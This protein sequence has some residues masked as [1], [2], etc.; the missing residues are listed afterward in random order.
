ML[1]CIRIGQAVFGAFAQMLPEK[2]PAC[3]GGCDYICS[4]A[5]YDKSRTPWNYSTA[6][7]YR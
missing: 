3:F 6:H 5:G 1:G 7:D 4:M 2:V